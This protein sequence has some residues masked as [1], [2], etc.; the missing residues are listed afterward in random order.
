MVGNKVPQSLKGG[1]AST[2]LS[3]SVIVRPWPA[4]RRILFRAPRIH[5]VNPKT[6]EVICAPVVRTVEAVRILLVGSRRPPSKT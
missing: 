3:A 1:T 6:R 5:L 4:S 2:L